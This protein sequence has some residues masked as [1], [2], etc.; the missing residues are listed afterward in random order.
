MSAD[1]RR[2]AAL[3]GS[4][5]V[6]RR[7]FSGRLLTTLTKEQV[8]ERMPAGARARVLSVMTGDEVYVTALWAIPG[9]G[10]RSVVMER[11]KLADLEPVEQSFDSLEH[12]PAAQATL[13]G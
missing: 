10:R 7:S 5:A 6:V 1:R 2:L 4:N 8:M 11:S 13:F 3:V 12:G 9:I